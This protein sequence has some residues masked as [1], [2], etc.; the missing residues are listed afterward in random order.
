MRVLTH[1]TRFGFGYLHLHRSPSLQSNS[2]D[3][4]NGIGRRRRVSFRLFSSAWQRSDSLF[5][6]DTELDSFSRM[7]R[8]NDRSSQSATRMHSRN[9]SFHTLRIRHGDVLVVCDYHRDRVTTEDVERW[10]RR[11]FK[12]PL[13]QTFNLK[14]ENRREVMLSSVPCP[15]GEIL[16]LEI[17][18]PQAQGWSLPLD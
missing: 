5:I 4:I 3:I 15:E 10:I 11:K 6:R 8:T 9:D 2:I 17:E 14:R 18:P 1:T 12:I 13:N 7:N 16:Q